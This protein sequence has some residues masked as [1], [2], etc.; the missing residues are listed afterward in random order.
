MMECPLCSITVNVRTEF[1]TRN[2]ANRRIGQKQTCMYVC[3]CVCVYDWS[4]NVSNRALLCVR[5][6]M[7]VYVCMR[8]RMWEANSHT[9]VRTPNTLLTNVSRVKARET[10]RESVNVDITHICAE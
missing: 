1:T 7:C 6:Y 8:A 2:F 5:V 10:Q 4:A 3:V 9:H